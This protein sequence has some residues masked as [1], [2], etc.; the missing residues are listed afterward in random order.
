[1]K[2]EAC[3]GGGSVASCCGG[4]NSA[5]SKGT[6]KRSHGRY[7]SSSRMPVRSARS[8]VRL[9]CSV[10]VTASASACPS[11]ISRSRASR[12]SCLAFSRAFAAAV[13]AFSFAH[14]S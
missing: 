8:S 14:A 13:L 5:V 7:G 11:A 6:L 12:C 2:S 9:A 10:R 1:M 4:L 3:G